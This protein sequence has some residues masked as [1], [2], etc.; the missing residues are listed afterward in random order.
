[1]GIYASATKDREPASRLAYFDRLSM[2]LAG[3]PVSKRWARLISRSSSTGT[4]PRVRAGADRTA[5]A[6]IGADPRRHLHDLDVSGITL[7]DGRWPKAQDRSAPGGRG[8]RSKPGRCL[9]AQQRAVGQTLQLD[10]SNERR[11]CNRRWS[12][13]RRPACAASTASP[14]P[15]SPGLRR[16]A[17]PG[18]T[19]WS[20]PVQNAEVRN[21][22][23]AA[24]WRVDPDQ[25]VDGPWAIQQR[26][27]DTTSYA[28][29]LATL[30]AMLAGIGIVLAAA[31]LHART[32]YWV[33][34]SA[35]GAWG[36]GGL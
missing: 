21:E 16:A 6:R 33:E 28:R 36:S 26:I 3:S 17:V 11:A 30:T 35:P 34:V 32:I 22:M 29:F 1:M 10:A 15:L 4:R 20:G 18:G 13:E 31:G 27:D 19:S 7:V 9:W 14:H 24:V 25:P 12:R 23:Q 8:D 5:R 2:S